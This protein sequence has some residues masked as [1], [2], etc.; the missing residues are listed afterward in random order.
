MI[1][2]VCAQ[3]EGLSAKT[4]QRFGRCPYFVL[5]DPEKQNVL[6]SIRNDNADAPGGAGPQSARL[7]SEHGVEAVITGNVG[8]K[9]EQALS[10]AGIMIYSGMEGT[11]GEAIQNFKADSL[12][13]VSGATVPEHS[14]FK[15]TKK[16]Q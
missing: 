16:Q 7:L 6:R 1:L 5:V 12:Q 9:A 3:G 8:P 14:G 11:V 15:R 13:I 2:A 4:D 10:A